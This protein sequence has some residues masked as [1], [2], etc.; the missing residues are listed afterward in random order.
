[1][2][3]DLLLILPTATVII[4]SLGGFLLTG[5]R[6]WLRRPRGVEAAELPDRTRDEIR[7]IVR[8]EMALML[9]ARD[10]EL[11]DLSER[12]DFAE[13]LLLQAR[14]PGVELQRE[15]TPV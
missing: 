14:L 10:G 15:P 11:E 4:V 7:S 2:D 5:W 9:D 3:P 13:R 8:E 6:M 1:M 12:I